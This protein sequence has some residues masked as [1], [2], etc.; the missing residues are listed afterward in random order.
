MISRRK[1]ASL[2]AVHDDDFS[3]VIYCFF[4]VWHFSLVERE[5]HSRKVPNSRLLRGIRGVIFVG[6]TWLAPDSIIIIIARSWR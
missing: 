3:C 4:E 5:L 1:V 6:Y 2:L